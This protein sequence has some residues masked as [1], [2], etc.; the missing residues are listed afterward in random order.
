MDNGKNWTVFEGDEEDSATLPEICLDDFQP[1][2]S[3]IKQGRVDVTINRALQAI[4]RLSAYSVDLRAFQSPNA[5]NK[6]L[7]VSGFTKI[8]HKIDGSIKRYKARLLEQGFLKEY[9]VEPL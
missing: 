3:C 5:G 7:A 2:I 9:H 4:N 6:P 8:K 1:T